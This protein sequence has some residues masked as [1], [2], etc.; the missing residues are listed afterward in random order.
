MI[1][2]FLNILLILGFFEL[3]ARDIHVVIA[4]KNAHKLA[5]VGGAFVARFPGDAL[6][7]TACS[8]VSGVP[9]QPVGKEIALRGARNR[10]QSL[11]PER[12]SCADYVVAIENYIEQ[13]PV[14]GAWSDSGLVLIQDSAQA[15]EFV[16]L[17][18]E[19]SVPEKYVALAQAAGLVAQEGYSV[20]IGQM[21]QESCVDKVIDGHDWH[22]EPEFGGIS[23]A[24]LLQDA[25]FKALHAQEIDLL[26][27]HI[28]QYPDFP[29]QGILFSDFLPILGDAQAFALC[30]DLL[31]ERYKMYNISAVV[32][33]E[34]RGFILGAALAYKLGIRFVPV[35]KP[36]KL[37]GPTYSVIY[38]KEYGS[39]TLVIAQSALQKGQ[40]VLIID[41]LIATGGSARA[42]IELV[43]VAGGVP[44]EFVTL[45][46]L[47]ELAHQARL[48]IPAFN[49]I[50]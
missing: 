11:S 41:D 14:T 34:S 9:E 35:R 27:S 28:V 22:R 15:A 26:K 6:I 17:T 19:T 32:G 24:Q 46:Q 36:G 12:V 29:K 40:R 20:T 50:D 4:S 45:L 33:L 43:T 48:P 39:D 49:L 23:R 21:I 18:K 30:I 38:K 37:P 8:S 31:A 44:V 5:A 2:S 47:K 42:A 7:F 1:K 10:V 3:A 16:A 25:L 13:S